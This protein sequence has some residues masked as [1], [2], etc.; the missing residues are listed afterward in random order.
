MLMPGL[1]GKRFWCSAGAMEAQGH[2][3]GSHSCRRF[4]GRLRWPHHRKAWKSSRLPTPQWLCS[5]AQNMARPTS[6]SP[7]RSVY[8]DFLG[9]SVL[10]IGPH[11]PRA[12]GWSALGQGREDR[13]DSSTCL[14]CTRFI[15]CL[16]SRIAL[17]G[18]HPSHDQAGMSLSFRPLT[19]PGVGGVCGGGGGWWVGCVARVLCGTTTTS[20]VR[21][22]RAGTVNGTCFFVL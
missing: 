7:V 11:W 3:E 17:C 2:G 20:P 1:Q 12:L 15:G 6:M 21:P 9:H 10:T 22:Q 5:P 14:S 4:Q 13:T 19:T 16:C 18:P 8:G